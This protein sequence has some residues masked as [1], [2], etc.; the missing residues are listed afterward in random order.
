MSYAYNKRKKN[1]KN[2]RT[3]INADGSETVAT[4]GKKSAKVRQALAELREVL[5]KNNG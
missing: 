3:Y 2:N 4:S 5:D 1:I